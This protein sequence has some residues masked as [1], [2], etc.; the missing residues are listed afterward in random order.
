[1]M[2]KKVTRYFYLALVVACL[3]LAVALLTSTSDAIVINSESVT[4][5]ND[6]WRYFVNGQPGAQGTITL[7][8]PIVA[9]A[10]DVVLLE[11][12]LPEDYPEG[13]TIC[14]RSSNQYV[15]VLVDDQELYQFGHRSSRPFG[16]SPGSPWN[17]IRMPKDTRGSRISIELISPYYNAGKYIPTVYYGSKNS[18][19]FYILEQ[20]LLGAAISSLIIVV[21]IL[22][23]IVCGFFRKQTKS[24]YLLYLAWFALLAGLWSLAESRIAQFAFNNQY[25]VALL[26]FFVFMLMPIPLLL[27]VAETHALHYKQPFYILCWLLLANCGVVTLLQLF[28]VVDL[29]ESLITTHLLIVVG[30]VMLI[31]TILLEIIKYRN[32]DTYILGLGTSIFAAVSMLDFVKFYGKSQS[33]YAFYFRFAVLFYI[34]ILTYYTVRKLMGMMTQ[35][36]RTK[37]LEQ[38]AF[39]DLL[40]DLQNRTSFEKAME[41]YRTGTVDCNG[42]WIGIFDINNLKV[43]N[44]TQGHKAGD[45]LLIAAVSCMKTVFEGHGEIYRIG[46]DEF[47]ILSTTALSE[48]LTPFEDE[49]ARIRDTQRLRLCVAYG[50]A[51]FDPDIDKTV[52]GLYVR[53]DS[54]MYEKKLED[55]SKERK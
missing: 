31:G 7:P 44:D 4:P 22:L 32:K 47:A 17:F 42:L 24:D 28:G 16:S 40:T 30:T 6:G 13:M 55:K 20:N 53:A 46:G 26:A 9:E 8:E 18:N 2:N 15:R 1:M 3:I 35:N 5:F 14:F 25:A 49:V 27:F 54:Y 36:M 45:E 43:V 10:G 34:L 23:F 52:D 33:G 12:T 41:P 50:A 11:N 37:M 39:V 19:V 21:A 38:L 29:F 51:C 48:L